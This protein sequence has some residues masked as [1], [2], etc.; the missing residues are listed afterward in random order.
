VQQIGSPRRLPYA[1][2]IAQI[3][4][5]SCDDVIL[6]P[7]NSTS[8]RNVVTGTDCSSACGD[9]NLFPLHSS[10]GN[11]TSVLKGHLGP[12]N[13]TVYRRPMQQ[14][15]S[16]GRDGLIFLWDGAERERREKS[17]SGGDQTVV[18]STRRYDFQSTHDHI[19]SFQQTS[20]SS[21]SGSGGAATRLDAILTNSSSLFTHNINNDED[22]AQDSDCDAWSVSSESSIPVERKRRD[23]AT[24][25]SQFTRR[26]VLSAALRRVIAQ[27]VL[28]A[29]GEGENEG[30]SVKVAERARGGVASSALTSGDNISGSRR[31]IDWDNV[32]LFEPTHTTFTSSSSSSSSSGS[33]NA[34]LEAILLDNSLLRS[35]V[36][37]VPPPVTAV[38][39]VRANRGTD[40]RSNTT[41]A[42]TATTTTVDDDG[43]KKQDRKKTVDNRAAILK[44]LGKKRGRK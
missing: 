28:R 18:S 43:G 41:T 9:I 39:A 44:Q 17:T 1:L 11:A 29:R 15:V 26:G 40:S 35:R 42:A 4:S 30:V 38:T 7:D 32:A 31:A 24:S 25:S 33:S 21:S 20:S 23:K 3:S 19:S 5:K 10:D 2:E 8:S 12:V 6:V 13:A 16:A 22:P 27:D 36:G 14:V 37:T 34:V